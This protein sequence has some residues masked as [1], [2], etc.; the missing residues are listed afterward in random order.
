M[1]ADSHAQAS[2]QEVNA[3][4]RYLLSA[5]LSYIDYNS[6]DDDLLAELQ[7][8]LGVHTRRI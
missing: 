7:I 6:F 2:F 4:F 3:S 1:G 5:N 8:I